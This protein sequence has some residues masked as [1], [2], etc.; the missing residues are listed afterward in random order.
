MAW[1][2][3]A[4]AATKQTND[5]MSGRLWQAQPRPE[6]AYICN[7]M[8]LGG[9]V[10][11]KSQSLKHTAQASLKQNATALPSRTS[12]QARPQSGDSFRA[13][14]SEAGAPQES[15]RYV[16]VVETLTPSLDV[17]TFGR[18]FLGSLNNQRK[19]CFLYL[20][21]CCPIPIE[22]ETILIYKP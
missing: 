6:E 4:E 19:T 21:S 22:A 14:Q 13:S 2:R 3:S 12:P 5:L 9:A 16:R 1:E 10:T 11:S 17:S 8:N 18:S 7:L 15:S 20:R